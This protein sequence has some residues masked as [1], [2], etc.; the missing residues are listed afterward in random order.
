MNK[1]DLSIREKMIMATIDCI[2]REGIQSLTTR[3]ITKEA[4]VNSAAINYYF[5]SKE[6]LVE[7]ALNQTLDEMSS[8]P[9]EI[10]DLKNLNS[11]ERLKMFFL[12]IMEGVSN[13][14]GITVAH[15]YD[16]LIR[17]SY[18]SPFVRRFN[19]F[20]TDLLEKT[21]DVRGKTK[22]EKYQMALIQMLSA[23][24]IPPLMPKLFRGFTKINFGDKKVR[25]LY[26]D[27]LVDHFFS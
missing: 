15:L 18:R 11:K 19:I 6:K 3:K 24:I 7:K 4:G 2:G 8:L 13:Y 17:N 10:L 9:E 27:N 21:S 25:K 20:L 16:P 22:E 5:G 1:E 26:V 23:V 12:A 14:P